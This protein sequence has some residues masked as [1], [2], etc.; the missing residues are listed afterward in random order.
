MSQAS[1]SITVTG[2]GS[3]QAAPDLFNINI[4]VEASRP[5]VRDAYSQASAA[6]NA[7]T[8]TLLAKGVAQNS[9]SST[10]LDVRVDTRWQEGAGTIVTGYTVSSTLSVPLGYGKGSEEIIAAIV[11]TGNNNVRLN[12]LTPVV[13][14]PSQAQDAAR[15]AAWADALRAAELYASLAGRT[16]G[17]VSGVVEVNVAQGGPRPLMARAA[18][19][20]DSAMEIAPGQ[21]D[22]T[23]AVQATWLLN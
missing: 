5:T 20:S 16:L 14:D 9:I 6:V 4:G 10:S 19:M 23:M 13:S 22:V 1:H 3:A 21:S 11:D 18:M 12:G 7:V 2:Q 8:A 15:T 17:E